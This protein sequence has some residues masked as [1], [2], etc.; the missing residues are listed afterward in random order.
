MAQRRAI[1]RSGTCEL[2][3]EFDDGGA[4]AALV[5]GGF[6]EGGDVGVGF[7]ELAQRAAEHAHARAVD[8]ADAG[9]PGEEG[10]VDVAFDFLLGFVGGAA[11]DV[12]LGGCVVEV[13]VGADGD[14]AAAAGGFEGGGHFDGFDVGDIGAGDAHLHLADG[15]LEEWRCRCRRS[16]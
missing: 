2:L 13:V 3:A 10:A 11:D 15:D 14:A 6:G 16:R 7:E 1:A 5:L 12:D 4:L 8:D 9:Q